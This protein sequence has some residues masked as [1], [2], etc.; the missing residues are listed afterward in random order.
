MPNKMGA[1]TPFDP[2]S[3]NALFATIL[4]RVS[5][6]KEGQV[7]MRRDFID[8]QSRV[9]KRIDAHEAKISS[10]ETS[11][12]IRTRQAKWAV[13]VIAVVGWTINAAIAWKQ[14]KP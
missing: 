10:L 13:A 5:E 7:A 14:A 1:D 4:E 3:H 9:F 2:N 6:V 8:T 12:A 11:D